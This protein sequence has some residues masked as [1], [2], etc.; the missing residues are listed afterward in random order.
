MYAG[1][2]LMLDI[3]ILIWNRT[4]YLQ[5]T[6]NDNFFLILIKYSS[7]SLKCEMHVIQ[8]FGRKGMHFTRLY[9]ITHQLNSSD[10]LFKYNRNPIVISLDIKKLFEQIK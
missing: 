3:F 7:I 4:S 9:G 1:T 8:I 6:L 2:L 5:K 10:N